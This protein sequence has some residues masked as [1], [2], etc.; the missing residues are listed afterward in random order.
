[1]A[2]TGRNDPC[3]CG[4][5]K[6]FKKCHGAASSTPPLGKLPGSIDDPDVVAFRALHH[7]TA[8]PVFV[9]FED[10]GYEE[11]YC[12]VSAKHAA[13]THGGARVHGWAVWQFE[14]M[15]LA[16]FHSVWRKPD[17]ALVDVTPPKFGASK[18]LF[19]ED[20]TL[21]IVDH[22]SVQAVY[23]D[24]SSLPDLPYWLNGKPH[25]EAEWAIANKAPDLVRYCQKLGLPDTSM[26]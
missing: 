10:R 17:G 4:S 19:V 6:K 24:R 1:M 2:K 8:K 7:L 11:N 9:E 20:P 23:V 3:P 13:L 18:V 15:A 25:N 14:G 22:G 12:H 26:V 5:G 16:E 21:S